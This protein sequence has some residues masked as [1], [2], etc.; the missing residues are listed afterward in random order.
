MWALLLTFFY[1]FF[2]FHFCCHIDMIEMN[3]FNFFIAFAGQWFQ[4]FILS[5]RLAVNIICFKTRNQTP[6]AD[7][8]QLQCTCI[9][10]QSFFFLFS[11]IF[12]FKLSIAHIK[13]NIEFMF[14]LIRLR[15]SDFVILSFF[16]SRNHCMPIILYALLLLILWLWFQ[17]LY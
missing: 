8:I 12:F 6:W 11:F 1:N 17:C 14:V 16:L 15:F 9:C 7:I 13:F 10:Y 5:K 2:F 3:L 4:L